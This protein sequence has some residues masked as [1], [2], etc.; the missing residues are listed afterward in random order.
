MKTKKCAYCEQDLDLARFRWKNKEKGWLQ[1]YCIDCNKEYNRSHYVKNK[2][3]Y[4]NKAKKYNQEY[5]QQISQKLLEYFSNHCCVDCGNSDPRV[6]EFDH[7]NG[8]TN[9]ISTMVSDK[10]TWSKI[11]EE[12]SRCEVRCA[13]CHR[14]VTMERLG[15]HRLNWI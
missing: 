5:K 6:L 4:I 8:K 14:I 12:I 10:Y 13:N 7:V 1:P 9:N 3:K 2:A 15:S 11:L